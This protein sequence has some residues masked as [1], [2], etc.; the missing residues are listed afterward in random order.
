MGK[1]DTIGRNGKTVVRRV[2]RYHQQAINHQRHGQPC[3]LCQRW[4]PLVVGAVIGLMAMDYLARCA[5]TA[6]LGWVAVKSG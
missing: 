1:R 5:G 3:H 2:C 4:T 6:P